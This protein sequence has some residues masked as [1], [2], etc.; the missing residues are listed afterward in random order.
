MSGKTGRTLGQ[1]AYEAYC[2]EPPAM[3]SSATGDLLPFWE[4]VDPGIA[5]RWEASAEAVR[6]AV[7]DK[8][9]D[10]P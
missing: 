4:Q 7:L 3:K 10:P 8:I 5:K 6:Q 1:V 9:Q 2:A